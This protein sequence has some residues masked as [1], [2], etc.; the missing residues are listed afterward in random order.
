[1]MR[2]GE[3]FKI[4]YRKLYFIVMAH[5]IPINAGLGHGVDMCF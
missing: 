4:T 3:E 5:R 2:T 1:M